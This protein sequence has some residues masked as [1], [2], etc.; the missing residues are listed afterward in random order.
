MVVSRQELLTRLPLPLFLHLGKGTQPS[1]TDLPP[2]QERQFLPC[3]ASG[4]IVAAGDSGH[5]LSFI[6]APT[7]PEAPVA[8]EV[9]DD[10]LDL[11]IQGRLAQRREGILCLS[12]T[13]LLLDEIFPELELDLLLLFCA[14]EMVVMSWVDEAD[15]LVLPVVRDV[16]F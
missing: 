14:G 11:V 16:P 6:L 5:D 10:S 9:A 8:E 7:G 2:L 4:S 3:L 15:I 13:I 12:G 1:L